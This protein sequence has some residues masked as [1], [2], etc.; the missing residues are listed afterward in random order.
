M[1]VKIIKAVSEWQTFTLQTPDL[2]FNLEI[3][4]K[5]KP[6]DPLASA[7]HN[8]ERTSGQ[9]SEYVR[10]CVLDSVVDWDLTTEG[11]P[12]PVTQENKDKYLKPLLGILIKDEVRCFGISVLEFARD[13]SN[14]L[15]N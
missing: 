6:N 1:D 5:V 9:M 12:L 4:L 10:K 2:G 8:E 14:F 3:K 7:D 11:Q 15:K 13:W